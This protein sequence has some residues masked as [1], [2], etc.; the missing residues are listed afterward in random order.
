MAMMDV[1]LLF[2]AVVILRK[3]FCRRVELVQTLPVNSRPVDMLPVL[4]DEFYIIPRQAAAVFCRMPVVPELGPVETKK[5]VL[6]AN[7]DDP[8]LV[9]GD[10][11]YFLR[12][13]EIFFVPVYRGID[14]I[15]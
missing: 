13:D 6:A 7:P 11:A 10:N 8:I 5:P 12:N 15:G 3:L 9:L 4:V 1:E 14:I 2:I